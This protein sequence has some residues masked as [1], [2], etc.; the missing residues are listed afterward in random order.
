MLIQ[1][2]F[3]AVLSAWPLLVRGVVWTI[4]LTIVGTGLGL[5]LGT[6]CAWARARNLGHRPTEIGRAHV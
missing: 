5:L 2:D 1:L 4:G 3:S 6:A